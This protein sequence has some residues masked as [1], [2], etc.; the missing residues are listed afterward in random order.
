[1]SQYLL[2]TNICIH[3]LKGEF[4]LKNK[5]HQIGVNN[6]YISEITIAELLYGAE[7]SSPARYQENLKTVRGFELAF[8]DQTLPTIMSFSIYAKEKARLKRSGRIVGEFDLLIGATALR[9][10][11]ILVTR[12]IKDFENLA[13][14]QLENWID[15]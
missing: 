4:D 15:N 6:C 2:D 12:N 13:G 3:Y 11:L 9:Y 5:V 14:I 7:N 10:D 1:M 8:S